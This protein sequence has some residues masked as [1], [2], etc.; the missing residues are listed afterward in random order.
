MGYVL[1]KES[2]PFPHPALKRG[3]SHT[4]R[5]N[6]DWRQ[7][8]GDGLRQS[9]PL[10]RRNAEKSEP[11]GISKP[12]LPHTDYLTFRAGPW[13]IVDWVAE[14]MAPIDFMV[15]PHPVHF[16]W[17]K[18]LLQWLVNLHQ[19]ENCWII[20]VEKQITR[21][22]HRNIAESLTIATSHLAF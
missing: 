3:W 7:V 13:T 21:S 14:N 5:R 9:N 10:F 2:I 8:Q 20:V 1:A 11:V 18:S 16:P 12:V 22:F 4:L 19:L 6:Q 15:W 17:K